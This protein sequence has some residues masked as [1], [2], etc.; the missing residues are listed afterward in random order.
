MQ[1]FFY[2]AALK[3]KP[4]MIS[5]SRKKIGVAPGTPTYTGHKEHTNFYIDIIDY[6]EETCEF[7]ETKDIAATFPYR[8]TDS[9]TWINI[10]GLHN[11]DDIQRLGEHYDLHPLIIE[12]IV[13]TRQRPKL[14]EYQ[15]YLFIVF[16]MMY[17]KDNEPCIEHV[18]VV[19]G[20]NYVITFQESEMDVFEPLRL[21]IKEAKGRIRSKKSDYLLFS[22]LDAVIDHYFLII[23]DLGETVENLETALFENNTKNNITIEIQNI[24]KE[25]LKVRRAVFPLREVLS[26]LEKTDTLLLHKNVKNYFRDLYDHTAQVIE[27]IEIARD[28]SWNL[29]EIYMSITGNKMNSIMKVLTIIATIFIPLTFIAGIYGMNFEY[30][31][32][33]N[34]KYSYYILWGIMVLVFVGMVFYFKRKKWL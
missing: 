3:A 2:M 23:E 24:K 16:K 14:D 31:P 17:H 12:D 8:D 4:K 27:T 29:M 6:T 13:D 34:F 32:E 10:N 15:D 19:L 28:M 9:V 18:S 5:K 25:V 11:T 1:I 30:M 7:I 22:I 20:R 33:L 26:R 21:R